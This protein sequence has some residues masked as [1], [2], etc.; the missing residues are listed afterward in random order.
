MR[1]RI[2]TFSITRHHIARVLARR[3]VTRIRVAAAT[4]LLQS[5]A[6]GMG[7]VRDRVAGLPGGTL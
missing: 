5:I 1:A 2:A 7:G 3:P 6:P 4:T